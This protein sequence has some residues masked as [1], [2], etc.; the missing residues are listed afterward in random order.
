M[1][2][3]AN[4]ASKRVFKLVTA[5]LTAG[6][7]SAYGLAQFGIFPQSDC[8]AGKRAYRIHP[9]MNDYPDLRKHNNCLAN[10]LTPSIYSEL[11]DKVLLYLN[12]S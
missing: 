1:A 10:H 6:T 12:F 9:P 5:S 7:I 2:S 8:D 11:R 3:F 4:F